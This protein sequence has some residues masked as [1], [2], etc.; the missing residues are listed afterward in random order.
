[1]RIVAVLLKFAQSRCRAHPPSWRLSRAVARR[2]FDRSETRPLFAFGRGLSYST[3][4]CINISVTPKAGNLSA[5]VSVVFEIK[6]T[7]ARAAAEVAEIYVGD[8]H[9][10][11]PRPVKEVK[12]FAK[13]NLQSGESKR[14][15]LTLDRR[16]FSYHDVNKKVE[17]PSG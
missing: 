9:A 4:A 3:F 5:P 1:M 16:A 12:N 6:N 13:L 17:C 15:T 7:G 11:V 14:V 2:C 8:S 10:S